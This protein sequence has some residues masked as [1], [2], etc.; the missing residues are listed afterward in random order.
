MELI[1]N[2]TRQAGFDNPRSFVNRVILQFVNQN[3]AGLEAFCRT[4]A[5]FGGNALITTPPASAKT[6][7]DPASAKL[8]GI[9]RFRSLQENPRSQTEL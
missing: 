1:H 5:P 7:R 6:R 2:Y 8:I 4:G 9:D 3:V